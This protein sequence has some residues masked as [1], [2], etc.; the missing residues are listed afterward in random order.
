MSA[1]NEMFQNIV[2]CENPECQMKNQHQH[3]F[4]P[5]EKHRTCLFTRPPK[6]DA[7]DEQPKQL[8]HEN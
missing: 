4:G 3:S 5:C 6:V 8:K 1:T 2:Y 7:S